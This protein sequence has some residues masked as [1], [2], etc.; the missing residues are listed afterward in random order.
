MDVRVEP[1]VERSLFLG[2]F[3]PAHGN[4]LSCW[5]RGSENFVAWGAGSENA[6]ELAKPPAS[7][8]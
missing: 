7:L 4:L 5:W 6:F 2:F 8:S 3:L 1:V